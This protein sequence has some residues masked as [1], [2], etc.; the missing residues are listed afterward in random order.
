MILISLTHKLLTAFI[1]TIILQT[2]NS[3]I[4]SR[5][6]NLKTDLKSSNAKLTKQV[7]SLNVIDE[8]ITIFFS[9]LDST[10]F[11]NKG[12]LPHRIVLAT[13]S[14]NKTFVS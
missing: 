7:S 5:M 6:L 13:K 14:K 9:D 10:E 4:F 3:I 12:F 2:I 11:P 1:W 8:K